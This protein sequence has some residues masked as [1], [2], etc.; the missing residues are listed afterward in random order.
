MGVGE[1]YNIALKRANKKQINFDVQQ[2]IDRS[3][4]IIGDYKGTKEQDEAIEVFIKTLM[5]GGKVVPGEGDR[6]LAWCKKKGR[7]LPSS[8]VV[9]LLNVD[10]A[11]GRMVVKYD[12]DH[13]KVFRSL[14]TYLSMGTRRYV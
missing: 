3:K 4:V 7:E 12:S 9:K 13:P 6:F 1:D 14:S 2:A 5:V 10:P 8:K 11:E